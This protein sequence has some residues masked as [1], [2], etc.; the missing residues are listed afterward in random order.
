MVRCCISL[1][2]Y[3]KYWIPF[4]P[5][6]VRPLGFLSFLFPLAHSSPLRLTLCNACL[7]ADDIRFRCIESYL[8]KLYFVL[9]FA[10]FFL[11]FRYI[12]LS[13]RVLECTI[14]VDFRFY[15][16]LFPRLSYL[17]IHAFAYGHALYVG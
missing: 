9:V 14:C 10:C 12:F 17:S 1:G 2:I 13:K 7:L 6:F 4:Y 5:L 3:G 16:G 15:S 8:Q 11:L